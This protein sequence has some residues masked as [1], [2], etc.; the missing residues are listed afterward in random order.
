MKRLQDGNTPEKR[1]FRVF[2]QNY[3]FLFEKKVARR[4]GEG[5]GR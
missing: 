5:G 3:L 1:Y 4:Y 2:P